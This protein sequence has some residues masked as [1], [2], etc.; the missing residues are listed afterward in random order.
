MSLQRLQ[1]LLTIR[2]AVMRAKNSLKDLSRE[3][4][5]FLAQFLEPLH[6][7]VHGRPKVTLKEVDDLFN[8]IG[9]TGETEKNKIKGFLEKFSAQNPEKSIVKNE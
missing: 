1:A 3:D 6:K 5:K 4:H 8:E 7:E 9:F 2:E